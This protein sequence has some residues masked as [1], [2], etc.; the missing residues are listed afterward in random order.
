MLDDGR[1]T[2]SKGRTVDFKNTVM[3]L[4]SNVRAHKIIEAGGDASEAESAVRGE[5][6]RKFRPESANE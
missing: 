2:D 1:L 3:I 5:L 6:Q 4:T